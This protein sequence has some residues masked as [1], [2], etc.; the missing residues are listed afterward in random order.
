MKKNFLFT[1][2]M[3]MATPVMAN[4]IP[5]SDVSSHTFQGF[6]APVY[7]LG[8]ITSGHGKDKEVFLKEVGLSLRAY[9]DKTKYE[10]CSLIFKKGDQWMVYI[11]SEHSQFACISF[12]PN[13][14]GWQSMQ[15]S[16]HTH[17]LSMYPNPTKGDCAFRPKLCENRS[18]G[19]FNSVAKKDDPYK[20]S[21]TDTKGIAGY[22]VTPNGL[23]YHDAHSDHVTKIGN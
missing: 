7:F 13:F 18:L 23:I 10:A 15:E 11:V 20:F 17:P 3:L 14:E 6:S 4:P 1:L 8:Q 21:N 9:T 22:L 5:L 16:I 2:M 19:E 12:N